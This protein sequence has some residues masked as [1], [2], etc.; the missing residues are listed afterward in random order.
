MT[1]PVLPNNAT[2]Q[3]VIFAVQRLAE[4]VRELDERNLDNISG[5]SGNQSNVT[6]DRT[7]DANSTTTD[8]LADVLGTLIAD[9][10]DKGV[11]Q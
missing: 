8:E 4:L 5:W 9:L 7:Y 10:I 6:T 11:L 2:L 3:D 1:V